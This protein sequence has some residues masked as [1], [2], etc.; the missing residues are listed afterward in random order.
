[1]FQLPAVVGFAFLTAITPGVFAQD[2]HAAD[3]TGA[4]GADSMLRHALP[5]PWDLAALTG[6]AHAVFIFVLDEVMIEDLAAVGA[7]LERAPA[8]APAAH[9]EPFQHPIGDIEIVDVLLDD[10]IAA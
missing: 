3:V 1:M 4:F 8:H 7:F 2:L 5:T 10:V 9:R 6:N